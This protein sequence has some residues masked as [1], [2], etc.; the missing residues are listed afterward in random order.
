MIKEADKDPKKHI[1]IKGS[2]V[3]NLKNLD[4][5][6]PKNK[7]VVVTGMS[8]SGKSSLAFDTLYAE[9]QR[10]YVESLS[11]Y[12]RQFLGRMNKPDVDYIKGIAPAIAIEQKVITSNPRSTVGTSTEIYDYLKLLFSRIGKTIS[13]VSG[14]IVKKDSVTDVINFIMTLPNETQATILCPLY[15]HNNRSL[16]EELAVLMQKGFVR[17][18]YQGK[19]SRIEAL[20]EEEGLDNTAW[21]SFEDA[22]TEKVKSKKTKIKDDGGL[23]ADSTTTTHHSL[24]NTHHAVHIVIDRITKDESDETMSRLG[25][26]IQTAFFEGKGDCYVRYQE[27]DA[28]TEKE[29]FF[30]DR[31]ELDGIK[32]EEPTPN[33]FSFNNPYGACKRCEGYGKVIGIDEDLVIPDKSKTIYEGAIAPW[34]GEKMREW[35]DELV[36]HALKFDFP[37]HRQYNQLTAQEQ[38][39]LWTGNKYFRGL[40]QFFKEMEAQT[41]KIQYR[42]MLSRY[43]GKTT[44]PE[45]KGSRLR[46]DATYVKINDH[47]ITDVVLM[48]LDKA[49]DFFNGLQLNETDITVGKR[50]LTEITNRLSFLNGV[51][52]SYLTLNRLSNTLSGGESQRINLATS[53]G[54]SLVGSIYVLDEPSIGLHPRDTQRLITVL[55]SLRDVGNTVLVVEHEEEITQA[56]DHIIDIGPAAG[57]HG[58]ELIFSGTYDEIIK[59]NNSLTGKYLSGR[60]KIAIPAQRRKWHD[61]IEIKGAR[62]NNLQHVTAKFPLGVFTAVTGVS[63][64]GKTSL[65]KRILA[66]AL[67]KTLGNYNGEQTGSYDAIEGDYAKIEQVELV[68]QNPIGRSSRSNPVTYVK[69]WDEIRNLYAARPAAKAAGLKPSAF[70]FNVEGGRCDV[71][72]GE[73]EV[74]IE[75]QFMA[76]IFLTC[77]TCEGKRFKQHILDVTYNEKNVSEVLSMTIEE[78]LEFFAAE[79]KIIAKIKPLFDVGLGYVQ[80]GQSSNTLSGGEAQRIKLASFLVKG[81]NP[82]KTLF[83]FDE[84]TT[85]LHFDD[86][87]KLLKSFDALLEHGNTIIVIEHNMDVIKC[88]DWVIDIGP[89]G[90]DRGGKVIFEGLPEDLIKVKGSYTG[91]FLKERF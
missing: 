58:G 41:Y 52:L 36:K 82:H 43:R 46:H 11:S 63:G 87:K 76:D 9:G 47:S 10:R 53:L 14:G 74:K 18:E 16:K 67:Q 19:I 28:E 1:I 77:E 31:F 86:I 54:S 57:T 48:A 91:E 81:N 13:P 69:A 51:G 89:E 25:D 38:R 34:R 15:P 12:A 37:I 75:M 90:G 8:G 85:G 55:K 17:V 62:E 22:D 33:F 70:S 79:P 83:I 88:A 71:C 44:C 56:A 26:S 73:G 7:L 64:S 61:F 66:P 72:Q 60:E 45:C 21:G 2:R 40:D 23:A 50:L 84:P 6:I 30:C 49:L 32:F 59:D 4:V 39:L 35:N 80:L 29:R 68:D 42:V 65:V 27:P 20:L 3:H 5:A 24:L 78:A